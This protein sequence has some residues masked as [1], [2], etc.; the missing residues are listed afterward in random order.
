[1]RPTKSNTVSILP[2][3]KVEESP[4]A[5]LAIDK[6]FLKAAGL[7]KVAGRKFSRLVHEAQEGKSFGM[8]E[9]LG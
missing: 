6:I 1:M 8:A 5:V 4:K 3:S 9:G 7:W 2:S